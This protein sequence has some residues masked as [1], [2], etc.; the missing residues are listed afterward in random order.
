VPAASLCVTPG[1]TVTVELWQRALTVPVRGFQAWGQFDSTAMTFSSGTYTATPYG[2][3][4]IT[5][6][7]ASGNNIDMAAGI[8]DFAGQLPTTA[9]AK[10]VTLTF[11]TTSMPDGPTVV[12]FRYRDPPSRF[13]RADGTELTPCLVQSP[14]ILIDGTAPVI[15]CPANKTV[16]C[17][18]STLPA[19]TGAATATDNLDDAPAITYTDV[20]TPNVGCTYTG[21]IA[22]TWKAEDCAGNFSTCVQTITVNDVTPPVITCPANVTIECDE[23]T[24]P[25]STD[26]LLAMEFDVNPVLS[27]TQAPGVWYTDRYAPAGFV[28]SLFDGDNRLEHSINAA[29]GASS[30]PPAYSSAFYN[31]QGR[32][33]DLPAST[34]SMTIDLYVPAA[35]EFTGRRMAGFWGTAFNSVPAVSAYPII[36]FTSS[37]DGSGVPRFRGWND[38][39]GWIDM[40][41]PTG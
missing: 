33:Y 30:R 38:T 36:E 18:E 25:S 35:W 34:T 13:T 3:P 20:W 14:T 2:L 11:G 1:E 27:P 12:S 4:V 40:G 31:T 17:D 37:P 19:N 41:L 5:P 21:T 7:T 29:D 24:D 9:D 8:N 10:L 16:E 26:V 28:S 23:S 6:I 15:T 32:K 39:A 22:R